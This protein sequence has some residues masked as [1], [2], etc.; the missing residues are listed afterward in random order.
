MILKITAE[1]LRAMM[2]H[3]QQD[4]P[5]E[6]CGYVAGRG[7]VIVQA[8]RMRNVDASPT[9]YTMDPREQLRVQRQ[10]R[11]EGLEHAG[12]YHSHV[13]TDAYPSKRDVAHAVAIQEFCQVPY[14]LVTLKDAQPRVRAFTISDGHVR[15]EEL[16]EVSPCPT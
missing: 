8:I 15:E 14:L 3:A 11:D 6:A 9:S 5:N 2:A 1:A 12:L 7:G 16:V 13:A 10:L 4:A